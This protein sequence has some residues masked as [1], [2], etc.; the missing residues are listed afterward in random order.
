MYQRRTTE[1]IRYDQVVGAGSPGRTTLTAT[2][3]FLASL[4][5]LGVI[6]ANFN[7]PAL[8]LGQRASV[9]DG[10]NLTFDKVDLLTVNAEW[11]VAGHTLSAELR[12]AVQPQ[13]CRAS[14]R[15]I[16]S[17][18]CLVSNPMPK[19]RTG[20]NKWTYA[21]NFV[22]H[23][24]RAT[25][26]RSTMTLVGSRSIRTARPHRTSGSIC[27]VHSADLPLCPGRDHLQPGLYAADRAFLPDRSGVR[28][29][30]RQRPFPH[31]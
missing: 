25:A 6:P 17:T 5:G 1:K 18:C 8:T 14:T 3:A 12:P 20:T 26:V 11:E 21:S 9:Q 31:R 4:G 27:P 2:Q 23:R 7:G 29:V 15:V 19:F 13:C 10:G 30:L 28:L 22:F 16:R 24:C